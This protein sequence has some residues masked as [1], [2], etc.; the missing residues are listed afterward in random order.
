MIKILTWASKIIRKVDVDLL[1]I[2]YW[3]CVFRILEEVG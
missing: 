3:N 2:L 1:T